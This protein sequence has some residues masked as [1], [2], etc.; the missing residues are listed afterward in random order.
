M[1][2]KYNIVAFV[3]FALFGSYLARGYVVP[4]AEKRGYYNY[5]DGELEVENGG[6]RTMARERQA[7]CPD[8]DRQTL[9]G[10]EGKSHWME[11]SA[12]DNIL[13]AAER[14]SEPL[15]KQ[16]AQIQRD[17]DELDDGDDDDDVDVDADVDADA[18]A[19][20]N[21]K[22]LDSDVNEYPQVEHSLSSMNNELKMRELVKSQKLTRQ[23]SELNTSKDKLKDG[24]DE[25]KP[26]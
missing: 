12:A 23:Q 20:F 13:D 2:Y 15:H 6:E 24:E 5:D 17:K 16:V 9:K 14:Q 3:C 4:E 22:A 21:G 11:F 7:E 26:H 10:R 25:N 18:E 8:Q 1:K 19:N